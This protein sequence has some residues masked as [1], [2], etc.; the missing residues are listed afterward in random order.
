VDL[1]QNKAID[2]M[3][4]IYALYDLQI[5]TFHF[6]QQLNQ[7]TRNDVTAFDTIQTGGVR[8]SQLQTSFKFLPN[9]PK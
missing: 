9:H 7:G 3:Q 5:V 6:L 8:A 4:E 2:E 1:P